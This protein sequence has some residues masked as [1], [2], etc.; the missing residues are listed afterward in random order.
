MGNVNIEIKFYALK[1]L[2]ICYKIEC[3]DSENYNTLIYENSI[4]ICNYNVV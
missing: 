2:E 3:Y 1:K 4:N